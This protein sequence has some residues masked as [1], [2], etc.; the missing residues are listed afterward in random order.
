MSN[1]KRL[2]VVVVL[3][4]AAIAVFMFVGLPLVQFGSANVAAQYV[5]GAEQL[6]GGTVAWQVRLYGDTQAYADA[7]LTQRSV[8][9][10]ATTP[11][12]TRAKYLIC[13]D[14][15]AKSAW[16]IYLSGQTLYIPA[17]TGEIVPR[18]YKDNQ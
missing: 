10:V 7:G 11:A 14:S 12:K 5:P 15:I 18:Q 1:N 9:L 4:L 6:C 3:A 13:T 2:S 17:G 16:K 8:V